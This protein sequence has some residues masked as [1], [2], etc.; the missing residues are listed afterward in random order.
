MDK[1]VAAVPV[2]D[3]MPHIMAALELTALRIAAV[4]AAGELLVALPLI[5]VHC[6]RRVKTAMFAAVLA[7]RVVIIKKYS[8]AAAAALVIQVALVVWRVTLS[9]VPGKMA[10]GVCW[11]C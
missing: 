11:C 4:L 5:A 2:V 8:T 7:A 10:L 1:P 9:P 6:K 3:E